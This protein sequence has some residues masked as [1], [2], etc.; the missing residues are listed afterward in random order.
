MPVA[1]APGWHGRGTGVACLGTPIREI[2]VS[3]LDT[4]PILLCYDGSI[5]SKR[6]IELAGDIFP[7]RRA[8]VLHVWSPA[9][10]VGAPYNALVPAPMPVYND[11]EV[12]EAAKHLSEEGARLASEAGFDAVAETAEAAFE[13]IWHAILEVANEY[14]A[15]LI[16]L[17]ARGLSTFESLLLGSVSHGVMQHARRPVLVIPPEV[18][19]AAIAAGTAGAAASA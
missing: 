19:V 17:G 13:G 6:A 8:V 15:A 2:A 9:T 11:S 5:G 16:V 3:K 14:D 10:I 18:D 12:H 4:N 1:R 7:R